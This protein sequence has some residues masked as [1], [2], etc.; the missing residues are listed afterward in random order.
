MSTLHICTSTLL[1]P[2]I[3]VHGSKASEHL[4]H[5]GHLNTRGNKLCDYYLIVSR[6]LEGA[7][8]TLQSAIKCHELYDCLCYHV[9]LHIIAMIIITSTQKSHLSIN[10][11]NSQTMQF[12]LSAHCP[13]SDLKFINVISSSSQAAAQSALNIYYSFNIT[14]G[15]R[16]SGNPIRSNSS[17]G[18]KKSCALSSLKH[19]SGQIMCI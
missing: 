7:I 16:P 19:F 9:F 5:I 13:S 15:N 12:L 14:E 8:Y 2:Q 18:K 3:L 1:P 11:A 10:T 4:L 17:G 6:D